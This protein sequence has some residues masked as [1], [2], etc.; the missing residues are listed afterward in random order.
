MRNVPVIALSYWSELHDD[1]KPES[2]YAAYRPGKKHAQ[3]VVSIPVSWARWLRFVLP[4]AVSS[5]D[6]KNDARDEANRKWLEWRGL[7][8]GL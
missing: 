7:G 2:G 8:A 1:T 4:H 3:V 5:E 6:F